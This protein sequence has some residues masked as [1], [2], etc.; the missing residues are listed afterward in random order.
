[1]FNLWLFCATGFG[2][3]SRDLLQE[4]VRGCG[5]VGA[6]IRAQGCSDTLL[7]PKSLGWSSAA[8]GCLNLPAQ[9]NGE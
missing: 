3:E 7:S 6:G 2:W 4:L 1:M 8:L 5:W 9:G